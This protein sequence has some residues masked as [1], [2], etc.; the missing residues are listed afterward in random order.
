MKKLSL[1]GLADFMT[2]SESIRRTILRQHKYPSEDEARAKIMY[3][4]EAKNRIAAYHR[5][6]H[7]ADW[8]IAQAMGLDRL[9]A[10]SSL[11][12]RRRLQCNARALRA[13]ARNFGNKQLEILDELRLSLHYGDVT[14]TVS[15]DL[16]A[17]ENRKEKIIKFGFANDETDKERVKIISQAM[18]ETAQ[19]A[20]LN[21][22]SSG[23]IYCDVHSGKE[24]RGA[25][26]GARM[27][28]NIEAA[29]ANISSIWNNI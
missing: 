11:S 29:C 19:S 25:R 1:K 12:A 24:H 10:M 26:L 18:F 22:P 27:R 16:H 8:L 21:L 13:Y 2:A 20:S 17:I 5:S 23:I 9:A 28:S 7:T 4:R 3:Y 14:I 6:N 15:P